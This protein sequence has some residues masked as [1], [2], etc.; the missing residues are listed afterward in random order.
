MSDF[1]SSSSA[2]GSVFDGQCRL[3]LDRLGLK[4]SRPFVVPE[5]GIEVDAA[6]T[7]SDGDEL[8]VE[9]KGSFLSERPGL[10]RT[11]TTKKA[12]ANGALISTLD[13]PPPYLIL[14]SHLPAVGSSGDS[15]LRV[16]MAAG[17]IDFVCCIY[18]PQDTARLA[19]WIEA[20]S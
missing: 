20:P 12:I 19:E 11:D 18:D 16:A 3:L 8:W 13:A 17:F 9:F 6:A 2:Q 4:H 15:M 7:T 5:L 10:R 1:Q 14:T